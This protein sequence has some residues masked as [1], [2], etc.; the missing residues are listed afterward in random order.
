[1]KKKVLSKPMIFFPEKEDVTVV[2]IGQRSILDMLEG[3][4]ISLLKYQAFEREG[5]GK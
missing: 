5:E 2:D 4:K 1:M 3:G